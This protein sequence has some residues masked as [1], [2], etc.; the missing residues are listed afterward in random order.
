MQTKAWSH[1]DLKIRI[2]LT[3]KRGAGWTVYGTISTAIIDHGYFEIHRSTNKKCF[4]NYLTNLKA[5]IK[6]EC[7]QKKLIMVLD[8]HSAHKGWEVC[9]LLESFCEYKR[10]PPYSCELN[11]VETVWSVLKP[12]VF[13]RFTEIMIDLKSDRE[14]C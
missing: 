7:Q 4:F 3:K 8:N 14:R 9:D 5:R 13:R 12:K 1:K 10:I 2:P 6:P 11:A